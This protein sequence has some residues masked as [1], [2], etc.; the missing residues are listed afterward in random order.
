MSKAAE[1]AALIGSQTA[2]SNRNLI[3]N[4]AM[5]VFQRASATTTATGSYDTADRF[6]IG[7]VT[8]AAYTTEQ[9][10]DTPTG[11]GYSLKA[12]VTTADTSLDAGHYAYIFQKIEAQ[13]LQHL[14]Y[15]TSSAKTLTLSF[16]VKSSKTGTYTINLN[17]PDSTDY[18]FVQ[19]YTVNSANTWEK[20][21]ITISPTAGD[22]SFITASAGAIV[23]DNGSGLEVGFSLAWGSNFTGGTSGSWSSNSS[24]YSTANQVNWLDST[25]NNFYLTQVQLEVGE[26][27]TPFEH[28]SF[29]DE[30]ARCQRYGFNIAQTVNGR[31][32]AGQA[33]SSTQAD[34]LVNHP[35]TM[36][37]APTLPSPD[38]TGANVTNGSGTNKASTA[39]ALQSA[40]PNVSR[41]R[42]TVSS[43]LTAGQ[44]SQLSFDATN[45]AFLDAEL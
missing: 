26:Q 5:Q 27:A 40:N 25:S 2:L 8:D 41:F 31:A 4:G 30:L 18:L 39:I 3:I 12:Q 9:S 17:K 34:I 35:V 23:N 19:E 7:K 22:T 44:G 15:G 38:A 10:T 6:V 45:D 20:K 1:L 29:A 28:R 11:T 43:G 16:W 24:H 21:A 13:N 32:G 33:V 36:R 14:A 42:V 37:A